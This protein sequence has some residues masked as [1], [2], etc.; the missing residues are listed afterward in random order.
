MSKEYRVKGR[1]WEGSWR[2]ADIRRTGTFVFITQV[3]QTKHGFAIAHTGKGEY[4]CDTSLHF[5]WQ[6]A[7]H[8][9]YISNKFYSAR[10]LVT[11]ARRFV[12]SIVESQEKQS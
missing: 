2:D 7:R 1:V 6:G 3:V 12:K 5:I 8:N 11:L 4:G 9:L 10:Y